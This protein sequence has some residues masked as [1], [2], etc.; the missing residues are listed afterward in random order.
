MNTFRLV[1]FALVT[2]PILAQTADL[3]GL[4]SDPSGL[5]VPNATINVQNQATGASHGVSSNHEGLYSI[6]ALPPGSYDISVEA[7]GFKSLHQN[8]IVLEVDQRATPG[9]HPC[10][11]AAPLKASRSKG[12]RRCSTRPTHP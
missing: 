9:F 5:P 4:I 3:S 7:T 11:S 1:L 8:G 10:P 6:P 2:S 12:A